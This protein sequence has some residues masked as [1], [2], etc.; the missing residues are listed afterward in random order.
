MMHYH[1]VF[2]DSGNTGAQVGLSVIMALLFI[3]TFLI[4]H[5][6]YTMIH[7]HLHSGLG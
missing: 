2:A 5:C 3:E 4:L 7:I 6:T 1:S